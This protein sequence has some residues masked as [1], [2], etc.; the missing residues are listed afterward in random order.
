MITATKYIIMGTL[1]AWLAARCERGQLKTA[2]AADLYEDWLKFTNPGAGWPNSFKAFGQA[3]TEYG[4]A[5]IRRSGGISYVGLSLKNS[6]EEFNYR[7]ALEMQAQR[8]KDG[9]I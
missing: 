5:K 7:I 3:M 4:F 6:D 9:E 2:S 1:D 8:R